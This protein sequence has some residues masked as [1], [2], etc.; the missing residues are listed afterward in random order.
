MHDPDVVAWE[1]RRPWPRRTTWG[2]Y[3]PSM[4]TIWHQD[5]GGYDCVDVCK[6]DSHWRWHV[7]H[8][9][10]QIHALQALR[11][12]LLTHCAWCGGRDRKGDPVNVSHQWDSPRGR[13]WRGEPG[14]YHAD[15]SGVVSAR[16]I[17]TCE[18]PAI[19]QLGECSNCGKHRGYGMTDRGLA[20]MRLQQTVPDGQRPSPELRARIREIY[21]TP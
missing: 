3:W 16:P 10:V 11:R 15:C 17:C 5:P 1:I 4:V 7:H 9:H 21:A 18:H 20:G 12:R 14:L 8:W 6:R 2:R 13:W 19:W